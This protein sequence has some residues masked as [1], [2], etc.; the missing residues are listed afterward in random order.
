MILRNGSRGLGNA[1]V[2]RAS[3]GVSPKQFFEK[4]SRWGGRHRQHARRARYPE[5]F[6]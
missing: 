5:I 2:S 4:S 1:H 6:A 3:F